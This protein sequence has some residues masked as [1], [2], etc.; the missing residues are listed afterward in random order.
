VGAF[1][2]HRPRLPLSGLPRTSALLEH[3]CAEV[4]N[5]VELARELACHLL[6]Q[7]LAHLAA[8][9]PALQFSLN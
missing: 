4:E 6:A 7:Y 9:E 5:D 1:R 8:Q 3:A 2:P